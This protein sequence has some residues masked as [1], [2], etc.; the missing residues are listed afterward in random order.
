MK[1]AFVTIRLCIVTPIWFYLMYKLL[2][3]VPATELMWFLFWVYMPFS[4]I[5]QIIQEGFLKVDE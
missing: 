3:L 2:D 5:M 1:L 4:F